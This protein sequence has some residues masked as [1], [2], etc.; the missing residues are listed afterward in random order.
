MKWFRDL[1]RRL[2]WSEIIGLIKK[3][4]ALRVKDAKWLI[5]HLKTEIQAG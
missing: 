5:Y 1:E 4:F 3:S 2:S